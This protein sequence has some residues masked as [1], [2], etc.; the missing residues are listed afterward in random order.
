MKK[1]P[2][3][4]TL[5]KDEEN[6]CV[7]CMH[8]ISMVSPMPYSFGDKI[9]S[10]IYLV[11]F[12]LVMIL[13]GIVALF[14]QM[15]VRESYNETLSLLDPSDDK[16]VKISLAITKV[17]FEIEVMAITS[18]VGLIVTIVGVILVLRKYFK[19]KKNNK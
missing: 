7:N 11:F 12:G 5:N 15:S 19:D 2:Y 13:G 1:C 9:S 17:N 8:D 14:S 18:V 4:K 10:Y 3:C 16:Y 6:T